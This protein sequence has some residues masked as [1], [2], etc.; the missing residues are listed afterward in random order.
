M[1]KEGY[2]GPLEK[3]DDYCWRIPKGYRAGNAR[4]GTDLCRRSA[5]PADPRR[6]G[7]R[8]GRQRGVPAGHPDG[9]PCHAR[10]PLGIRLLH[11]RRLRHRSRTRMESFPPAA[12]ATTSTAGSGWF[13]RISC[14]GH[15]TANAE[16]DGRALPAGS[17]R[18]GRGRPVPVQR[19]RDCSGCWGKGRNSSKRKGLATGGDVERTEAGGCLARRGA[20]SVS[21]RALE[22]G[23][24]QCGTL[25]SG[26]HFLEVQVV[27]EVLDETAARTMGLAKGESA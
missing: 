21:P 3:I 9:Q 8:A 2:H 10:Y 27:D 17:G 4:R 15:R 23:G 11:R 5:H 25:G 24:G 22:R 1:T 19:P 16:T 20:G 13:A 6:S 26:N 7:P 14:I 18:S 12:S